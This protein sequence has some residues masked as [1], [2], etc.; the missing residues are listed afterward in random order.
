MLVTTDSGQIMRLSGHLGAVTP[1]TTEEAQVPRL[2]NNVTALSQQETSLRITF[3]KL[4]PDLVA[5]QAAG[6]DIPSELLALLRNYNT[7]VGTFMEAAKIWLQARAQTPSSDLPDPSAQAIS[8][9]TFDLPAAS[10]GL[11]SWFGAKVPA[12]TIKI[13][14]GIVGQEI[15]TSLSGYMNSPFAGYYSGTQLGIGPLAIAI[16]ILLGLAIVGATIILT[17][18]A[19]QTSDT[20]AANQAITA[21]A[22]NRVKEVESDR[23]LFVST[24]DACIGNSTDQTVRLTCITAA[25]DVLKASKEGRPASQKPFSSVSVGLWTVLGVIG[26]LGAAGGIGYVIYRRRSGGHVPRASKMKSRG[27]D[28]DDGEDFGDDE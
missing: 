5:L 22:Q 26:V 15:S 14:H 7:A 16:V 12:A 28:H 27:Y 17:A 6:K 11:G 25:K 18:R 21:Q 23:D 3:A 19:L 24:R 2:T 8:V 1:T 9:P 20:A 4:L 13:K 10:S